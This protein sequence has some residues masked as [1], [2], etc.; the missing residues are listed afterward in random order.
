MSS[1]TNLGTADAR[2]APTA[3]HQEDELSS[4]FLQVCRGRAEL[5]AEVEHEDGVVGDVLVK[6]LPD[7]FRLQGRSRGCKNPGE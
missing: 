5:G 2:A 1:S 6:A 3:V 7:D 4:S